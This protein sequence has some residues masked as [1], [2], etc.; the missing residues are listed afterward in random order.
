MFHKI[1]WDLVCHIESHDDVIKWKHFPRNWSFVRGINRSP[2]N[3]PQRPVTQSF[4][5]FDLHLDK[6]LSRQSWGWW[7]ET[8]SRSLWRHCNDLA[9]SANVLNVFE[10]ENNHKTLWNIW[11]WYSYIY[12][13]IQRDTTK[14]LCIFYKNKFYIKCS[15]SVC[16]GKYLKYV[17][18]NRCITNS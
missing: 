16:F 9:W 6:P 10:F 8:R 13:Y 1:S 15:H 14:Y 4:E 5:V 18:W 2:M 7:N 11:L 17:L 3:S 12:I